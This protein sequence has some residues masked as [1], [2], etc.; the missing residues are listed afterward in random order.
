MLVEK[1]GHER[2]TAE[3]EVRR[4]FGGDYIPLYQCAYMLGAMQLWDLRRELVDSKKMTQKE[5]HDRILQANEMPIELLRAYLTGEKLTP[6]YATN[7][8]FADHR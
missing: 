4:S 8:R 6:D 1:V 7:W 2:S 3:G 5:F